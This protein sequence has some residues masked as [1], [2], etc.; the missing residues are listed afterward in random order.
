MKYLLDTHALIWFQEGGPKIPEGAM[1]EIQS[2]ANSIFFSQVSLLEIA[3][4]QKTG[5]LPQF[6]ATVTDV[7]EQAITDNFT[8]LPLQN[9]HIETYEKI[10]L[11]A[12]HRDPFD[13]ILI[14]TAHAEKLTIIT[15]DSNFNLYPNFV[16]ILWH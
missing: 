7:Y 10:P 5:K 9:N 13:R 15:I 12:A 16:K 14:A 1:Q 2:P 3:I 8:Y 6:E 11:L 4:K